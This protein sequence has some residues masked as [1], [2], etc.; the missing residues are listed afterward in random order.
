MSSWKPA[1]ITH[2]D[3]SH[4]KV[5]PR[6]LAHSHTKREDRIKA[7]NKFL[8]LKKKGD[9]PCQEYFNFNA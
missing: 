9:K 8:K 7:Y 1:F 4:Q 3:I 2:I 5:T 6:D